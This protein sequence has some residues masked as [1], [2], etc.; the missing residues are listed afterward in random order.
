MV[1]LLDKTLKHYAK[2]I[3]KDLQK[4]IENILGSSAFLLVNVLLIIKLN[5]GKLLMVLPLLLKNITY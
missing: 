3:K 4:D 1:D 2:I 5:L